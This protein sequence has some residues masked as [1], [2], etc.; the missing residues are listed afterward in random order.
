M[1]IAHIIMTPMTGVGI[2][3]G[4]RGQEWLDYRIEIFKNYTLKSLVNQTNKNFLHI[5]SFRQEEEN[6]KSV[7]NLAQYIETTYP[8]YKAAFTFD[9]LMYYDDK[10]SRNPKNVI[11]NLGR[12]AREI[13]RNNE[14][15]GMNPSSALADAVIKFG[16]LAGNPNRTLAKRL[17][18]TLANIRKIIPKETGWIFFTRIDSDDMFRN[19]TVELIQTEQPG[20]KKALIMRKNL[21]KKE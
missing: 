16:F 12:V 6:N 4:F 17:S 10:F 14:A 7:E 5:L 15:F 2:K 13:Y 21:I 18:N 9:G 19:D 3:Q 20:F 8:D 11:M 1:K